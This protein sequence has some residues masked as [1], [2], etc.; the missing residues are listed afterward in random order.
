MN[1]SKRGHGKQKIQWRWKKESQSRAESAVM[2]GQEDPRWRILQ[3]NEKKR[4]CRKEA[5]LR[6]REREKEREREAK[7]WASFRVLVMESLRI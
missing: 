2:E 4:T 3:R 5:K 6:V 7:M 1:H